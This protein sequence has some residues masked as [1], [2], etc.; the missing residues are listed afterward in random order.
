[1]CRCSLLWIK[2]NFNSAS[3]WLSFHIRLGS[4]SSIDS[5]WRLFVG[6]KIS[7]HPWNR[8]DRKRTCKSEHDMEC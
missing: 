8:F 2:L 1:M 6:N 4:F 3:S 5:L 7:T